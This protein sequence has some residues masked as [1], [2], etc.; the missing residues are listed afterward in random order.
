MD[1]S[2]CPRSHAL[3]ESCPC[4]YS[5]LNFLDNEVQFWR[6]RAK[7]CHLLGQHAHNTGRDWH[8]LTG[9]GRWE[10][11]QTWAA[12]RTAVDEVQP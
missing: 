8:L 2:T 6:D 1:V 10:A 7:A 5:A 9:R 4:G 3:V 12:L 11:I